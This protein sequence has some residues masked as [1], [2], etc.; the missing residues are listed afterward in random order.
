ML[1]L[2]RSWQIYAGIFLCVILSLP[3][4]TW[5]LWPNSLFPSPAQGYKV[6]VLI[7]NIN[8]QNTN[9]EKVF[10][11]VTTEKPDVAI[12]MEVDKTWQAKLDTLSDLLPYSSG[13]CSSC[14]LGILVYTNQL[15][16][17]S[18]VEFFGADHNSSIIA[19]LTIAEQLV[20]LVATHPFPP[21]KPEFFKSRNQQLDRISEYLAGVDN[22]IILAGDLNTTMWSPYYRRLVNKTGL[23]NARKGFGILTTWPTAGTYK[24]LPDWFTFLLR[25][26]IDHCLISE[27][28]KVTNIYTGKETGS[29]H[30]PL[31]VD[32]QVVN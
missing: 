25:I 21:L 16:N 15:L 10:D 28:L 22:R 26:P 8:T 18:R 11:L 9:Y 17:D 12:F 2:R 1:L 24:K 13:Q 31:I 29:D 6:R 5:Y 23:K 14:N 7:S 4:L 27:G 19:Q 20:T 30:L 32:L 3:I